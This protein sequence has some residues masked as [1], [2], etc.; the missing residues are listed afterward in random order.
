MFLIMDNTGYYIFLFFLHKTTL[1]SSVTFLLLFWLIKGL[2]QQ[3][4]VAAREAQPLWRG[5]V[6]VASGKGTSARKEGWWFC[7]VLLHCVAPHRST[8][9]SLRRGIV[10]RVSCREWNSRARDLRA[11]RPQDKE[12]ETNKEGDAYW[13]GKVRVAREYWYFFFFYY[14]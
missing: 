14:L 11:S 3:F 5:T 10:R 8:S 4:V 13:W 1:I 6:C 12:R 2:H 7:Q 9:E